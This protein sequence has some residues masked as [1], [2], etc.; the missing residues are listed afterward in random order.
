MFRLA[1]LLLVLPLAAHAAAPPP[2][3]RDQ[4]GDPLPPGARLR[5]GSVR[6]RA[7]IGDKP[8]CVAGDL[9]FGPDSRTLLVAGRARS[10]TLLVASRGRAGIWDARNGRHRHT[11]S[12]SGPLLLPPEAAP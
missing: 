8:V 7:M 2:L 10:R 9:L 4:H 12:L 6:F 3:L 11:L 5:L 1:W